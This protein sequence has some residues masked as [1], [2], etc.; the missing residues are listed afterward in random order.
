VDFYQFL[1]RSWMKV[2]FP[3]LVINE[4]LSIVRNEQHG[5]KNKNFKHMSIKRN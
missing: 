5:A 1:N 3:S 4:V 2:L